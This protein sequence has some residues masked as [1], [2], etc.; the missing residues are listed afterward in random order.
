MAKFKTLGRAIQP[1]Q[2]ANNIYIHFIAHA[3]TKLKRYGGRS[4]DINLF[5]G[6]ILDDECLKINVPMNN[7]PTTHQQ[8][9]DNL[10]TY[11]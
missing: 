10:P 6:M 8:P 4:E 7:P 2:L 9:T 1:S 5:H 11:R 3:G